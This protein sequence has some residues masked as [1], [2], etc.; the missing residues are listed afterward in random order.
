MVVLGLTSS[1]SEAILLAF[2][3]SIS[4]TSVK[5]LRQLRRA[6][7]SHS[8][9]GFQQHL[10]RMLTAQNVV[11]GLLLAVPYAVASGFT[12]LYVRPTS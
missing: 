1:W 9:P 6:G 10:V 5:K 12:F 2:A 8:H 11:M 7:P 4:A 3:Y